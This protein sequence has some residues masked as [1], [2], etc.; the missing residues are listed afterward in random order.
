MFFAY[1]LGNALTFPLAFGATAVLMAERPTPAAVYARLRRYRPTL[2][3][4]VPTLYAAMLAAA[5]SPSPR[6]LR[7]RA[8]VSAGECLPPSIGEAWSRRFGVDILDGI[9]STEML[10]I[11]LSN[12]LNDV[13]YGTTGIAV[14]GYEVRL[15]DEE[16]RPVRA[17]EIGE[18]Q[19]SG[20][21]AAIHYWNNREKTRDAFQGRWTRTG[22]KYYLNELGRY[23]HAG[24]TDDMLKVGGIYVSPVEVENALVSHPEVQEAAVIGREDDAGLVKPL[25]FV[26]LREGSAACDALAETLKQH[27]KARLAPYKYPRWIKFLPELPKTTTGKTQRFRLREMLKDQAHMDPA[28]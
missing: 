14:P 6:E 20:P 3:C 10:H 1:G 5:D 18:L 25:A 9:G 17:G 13:R 28:S 7:L 22:D 11:F 15:L 12:R 4:A 16:E 8:C 2:F 26:V 23:V 19:V 21:T 27:V 24:R